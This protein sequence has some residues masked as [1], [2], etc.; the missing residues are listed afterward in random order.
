MSC[1]FAKGPELLTA[2]TANSAGNLG[3]SLIYIKVNGSDLAIGLDGRTERWEM[4][5][6][7]YFKHTPNS[8]QNN[9][10]IGSYLGYIIP[11]QGKVNFSFGLSG[12]IEIQDNSSVT[13]YDLG[14]YNDIYF[15]S[16]THYRIFTRGIFFKLT[17][18]GDFLIFM[19]ELMSVNMTLMRKML[20]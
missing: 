16:N 11:V 10:N 20:I 6:N 17:M 7:T 15:N 1:A 14:A 2:P 9:W 3:L 5:I 18:I 4:G 12:N 8:S 19:S 13:P